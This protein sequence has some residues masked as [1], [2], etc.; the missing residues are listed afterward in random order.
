MFPKSGAPMETDAHARALLNISF[1]FP[2]KETL[3]GHEGGKDVSLT[4]RPHLPPRK[5]SWYSFMLE[6]E[7]T[8]GP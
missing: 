2:S 6:S 7:P 4:H 8:L 1:R 3:P 5:Y